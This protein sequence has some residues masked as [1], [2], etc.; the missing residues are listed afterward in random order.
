MCIVVSGFFE[1]LASI[2]SLS[3]MQVCHLKCAV[4]KGD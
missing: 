3:L 1:M 4:Y 2:V